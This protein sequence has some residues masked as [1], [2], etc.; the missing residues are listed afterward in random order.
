MNTA[1]EIL[2]KVNEFL[3]TLPYDRQPASLDDPVT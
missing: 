3:A 1:N 2:Q